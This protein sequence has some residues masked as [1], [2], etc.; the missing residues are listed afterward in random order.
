MSKTRWGS[1]LDAVITFLN[2]K[3]LRFRTVREKNICHMVFHDEST[4]ED[5][6]VVIET[7]EDKD[8]IVINTLCVDKCPEAR[9]SAVCEFIAKANYGLHVGCW[10]IDMNDGECE[11][12][13][14]VNCAGVSDVPRLL[15]MLFERNRKT[16]WR[17][18]PGLKRVFNG[19]DPI[20][21][22]NAVESRGSDDQDAVLAAALMAA[23]LRSGSS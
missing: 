17:Y 11:Y 5:A 19:E 20:Q 8:V 1:Y 21:A 12:R 3:G 10:N 13:T 6:N 4:N 9:R 23:L 2:E 14:A 16:F 22:C 18:L 7:H 15:K